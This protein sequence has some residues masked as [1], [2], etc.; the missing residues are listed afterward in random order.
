LAR[1]ALD[2]GGSALSEALHKRFRS[3]KEVL[4]KLGLDESLLEQ[5]EREMM[6]GRDEDARSRDNMMRR[7]R[8]QEMMSELSPDRRNRDMRSRDQEEPG[9]GEERELEEM[10]AMLRDMTAE[11]RRMVADWMRGRMPTYDRRMGRDDPVPFMGMPEPGG[12]MYGSTNWSDA[13]PLRHR[14]SQNRARLRRR[15][16]PRRSRLRHESEAGRADSRGVRKPM[17]ALGVVDGKVPRF[18]RLAMSRFRDDPI[19]ATAATTTV[20]R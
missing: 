3:A 20:I 13:F 9:E 8:D 18:W 4:R 15:G 16:G 2:E 7:G 17:T 19:G 10:P 11:D 6:R 1:L 12:T 14:P 5:G